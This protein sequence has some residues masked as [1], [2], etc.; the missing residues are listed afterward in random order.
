MPDPPAALQICDVVS[1]LGIHIIYKQPDG[2]P[3][4]LPFMFNCIRS[5]KP[6][7]MEGSLNTFA[8]ASGPSPSLAWSIFRRFLAMA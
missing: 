3:E 2:W 4:L 8:Q 5:Q 7:L 6:I 1:E